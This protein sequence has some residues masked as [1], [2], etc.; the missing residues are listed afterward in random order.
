MC[1][2]GD[3]LP[4][5]VALKPRVSDVIT[6]FQILPEDRLGLVS[7]VTEYCGVPND[8]A[9]NL[10]ILNRSGV[11]GWQWCDVGDQ[12]WFVEN[13][14][15]LVSEDA[16]VGEIFLPRRLIAGNDGIVKL[17]SATDEFVLRNRNIRSAGEG[18]GGQKCD[19]RKFHKKE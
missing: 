16:V 18:Y 5:A 9:L 2:T 13:A 10:L 15:F 1:L 4:I 14:S 19:E 11:S 17:L 8:P 6:R 12:F 3:D 7:V